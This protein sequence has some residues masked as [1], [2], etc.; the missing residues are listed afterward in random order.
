M[1]VDGAPPL[2][3]A[4]TLWRAAVIGR[5]PAGLA[6]KQHVKSRGKWLRE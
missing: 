3:F 4:G 1:N 6:L 2:G 5:G